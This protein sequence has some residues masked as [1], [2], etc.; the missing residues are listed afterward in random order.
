MSINSDSIIIGVADGEIVIATWKDG[1]YNGNSYRELCTEE[2]GEERARERLTDPEHWDDLGMLKKD[3]FLNNFINFDDVAD[4][5][6]SSDGWQ[7]VNG[8]WCLIGKYEEEDIYASWGSGFS[9]HEK[10]K[11]KGSDKD[12]VVARLMS[13]EYD[14]LEVAFITEKQLNDIQS[15]KKVNINQDRNKVVKELIEEH[16]FPFNER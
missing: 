7:N 1:R 3:S 11:I 6:L 12:K 9:C 8:E 5:C 13:E 10:L 15:D 14:Y 16:D 2:Y 4:H